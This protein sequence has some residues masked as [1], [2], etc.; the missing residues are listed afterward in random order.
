MLIDK[1]TLDFFAQHPHNRYECSW[2]GQC[3]KWN[4]DPEVVLNDPEPCFRCKIGQWRIK[5]GDTLFPAYKN[6]EERQ[7]YKKERRNLGED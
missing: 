2:C 7:K 3:A 6:W 5:E 1:E 4:E